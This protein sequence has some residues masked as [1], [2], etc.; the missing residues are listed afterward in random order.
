MDEIF[1][2]AEAIEAH[3][4]YCGWLMHLVL[5][6]LYKRG[7]ADLVPM[8]GPYPGLYLAAK[9][10]HAR[11]YKSPFVYVL[12]RVRTDPR[13][14]I[15]GGIHASLA[16]FA[17]NGHVEE[18]YSPR[19]WHL[20][21]RH[22]NETQWPNGSYWFPAEVMR[23]VPKDTRR[24]HEK[25]GFKA[26]FEPYPSSLPSYYRNFDLQAYKEYLAD[27]S[28]AV[29]RDRDMSWYAYWFSDYRWRTHEC[30]LVQW[31]GPGNPVC[32]DRFNLYRLITRRSKL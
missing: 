32:E 5:I 21:K 20:I 25:E 1:G 10:R 30:A 24:F 14:S 16:W 26:E 3:K 12:S 15:A 4:T 31:G 6:N 13:G 29:L 19:Y 22:P 28:T 7:F 11:D 8:A 23:R 9:A 27:P 2:D 18:S 17:A